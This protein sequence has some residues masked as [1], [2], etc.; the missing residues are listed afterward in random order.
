[1]NQ[2]NYPRGQFGFDFASIRELIH[3]YFDVS[4]VFLL[5]IL[6]SIICFVGMGAIMVT[7]DSKSDLAGM[8]IIGLSLAIVAIG[9]LAIS[10]YYRAIKRGST[11]MNWTSGM[12]LAMTLVVVLLGIIGLFI[13]RSMMSGQLK[14]A[15]LRLGF[16]A[17][18]KKVLE[19]LDVM[20]SSM[21]QHH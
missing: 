4:K 18:R 11:A 3:A 19:Q 16:L 1:M 10:G 13:V 7:I 21:P 20:E 8:V 15:G 2:S 17:Q 5:T 6:F 14:Q 9:L 12:V